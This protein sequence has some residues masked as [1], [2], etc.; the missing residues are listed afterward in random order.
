MGA[1]LSLALQWLRG[2]IP[3]ARVLM[4]GLNGAG[5]TTLL[6]QL[7]LG[8]PVTTIPTIGFNVETVQHMNVELN[9]WDIGGQRKLDTLWRNY[10][11]MVHTSE[12]YCAVEGPD[13]CTVRAIVFV[14]DA[15]D[16]GRVDDAREEVRRVASYAE[17]HASQRE[18]LAGPL[19]VVA[20][21]SDLEG[22]MSA[23]ELEQALG[24][25]EWELARPYKVCSASAL[26][27]EGV[28][29]SMDWL[30]DALQR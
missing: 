18:H 5:K 12:K 29:A 16:R 10:L 25:T 2:A 13:P 28:R 30:V 22:A 6:Y 27:G 24:L 3:Q 20:N 21:K 8:K 19:L 4:V 26:T 11:N 1:I 23:Q 7:H 9:V 15:A 17:T 14:V